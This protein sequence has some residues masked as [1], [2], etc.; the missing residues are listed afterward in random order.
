M[1]FR[2]GMFVILILSLLAFPAAQAQS[3]GQQQEPEKKPPA[4]VGN[5]IKGEARVRVTPVY[6][7]FAEMEGIAGK[8]VVEATIDTEGNIINARAISGP[9]LLREA[10][11]KAALGWKFTPTTISGSPVKVIGTITF[12]F[13]LG[14]YR[15]LTSFDSEKEAKVESGD[16]TPAIDGLK[17]QATDQAEKVFQDTQEI[18]K[19]RQEVSASPD[20]PEGHFYL[21]IALVKQSRYEEAR[22]SFSEALQ[23]KPDWLDARFNFGTTNFY[24][25]KYEAAIESYKQALALDPKIDENPKAALIYVWLGMAYRKLGRYDDSLQ[26]YEQSI[27]V[28]PDFAEAI[29]YKGWVHGLLGRYDK[30][31][32]AFKQVVQLRPDMAGAYHYL[33]LSYWKLAEKERAI[34]AFNQAKSLKPEFGNSYYTLAQ[35]Y[36]NTGDRKAALNEYEELKKINKA[37]AEC[38]LK[39]IKNK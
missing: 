2:R 15:Q 8:V 3:A 38:L 33:G 5:V 30:A 26:A 19:R 9:E 39:E 11:E 31:L 17:P 22:Q 29:F 23:M 7:P 6:P 25:G 14:C 37:M 35:L 12:N 16:Q 28:R 21:G 24:L 10:A 32:M 18:Q 27:K 34:E 36:L 1:I 20:S 4:P 13:D